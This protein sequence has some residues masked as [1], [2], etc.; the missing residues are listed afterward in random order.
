[1]RE[2]TNN[3]YIYSTL[4]MLYDIGMQ[5]QVE[6]YRHLLKHKNYL[7]YLDVYM[8]EHPEHPKTNNNDASEHTTEDVL[9][10]R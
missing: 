10:Q 5:K 7:R 8:A 3:H 9:W 2:Y 4:R 1:M 6:Q